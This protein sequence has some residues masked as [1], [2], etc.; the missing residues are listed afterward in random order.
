MMYIIILVLSTMED[1]MHWDWGMTPGTP[2]TNFTFN[3]SMG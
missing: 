1:A 2:F 3:L